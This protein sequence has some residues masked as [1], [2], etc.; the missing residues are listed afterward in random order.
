MTQAGHR[1]CGVRS[2]EAIAGGRVDFDAD[3]GLEAGV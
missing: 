2:S 3:L 1:R